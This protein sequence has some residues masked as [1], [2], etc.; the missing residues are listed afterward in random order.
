VSVAAET[1]ILSEEALA[2]IERLHREFDGRRKELLARRQERLERLTAGEKPGFLP[3]T[4]EIRNGDWKVAPAPADLQDRRCEITG[5]VDRKMMINA[6]NSGARVFMADFEDSCSPTWENVVT[7]QQNVKDAVRRTIRLE[8]PEKT[9]ELGERIATLMIRPRGWHLV[10]RHHEIGGE[11]VSGSLFDFGLVMFHNAEEMLERGTGPYFYL[12]KLESHQEARLWA[13]VFAFA[14][15]EL[16]IPRGSIRCTVLIETILA[17]FEMEEILYELREYGCALN[18]GR[19]DYIF[20][21]IKKLGAVLPDRAKV[22][23]SV[24][25]MRAYTEL[26]V[27]TCHR[28]DAHAIGGMA[29]FIPSRRDPEV[30]RVAIEKVREDKELEASSG[31]DGTWVAHPDLVPIATEVFD[32]YL[33]EKPN[34]VDRKREDVHVTAEQLLDFAIPGAD[35]TPAGLHTNV[36]VGARYIDSWLKGVGAAAIDNL[37]EDAATAEISRAQVWSWVEHGDV[38]PEQVRAELD[39]VDASEE[40]KELFAEL[41]LQDEFVEFLTLPAYARLT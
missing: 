10:E 31:F 20:S 38:T 40:A 1:E 11:P 6:L 15:S 13:D 14:E 17:A 35:I 29:A 36:S 34:Q 18:A 24:P 33:G 3:E 19:W 41:A 37:M 39:E 23:M 32:R 30:N 26:L 16:G 2:F 25:F 28:H 4:E 9:Y 8:T 22:T 5:P 7:G 27:R 21:V 12:P